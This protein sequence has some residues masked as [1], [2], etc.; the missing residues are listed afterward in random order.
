MRYSLAA[1]ALAGLSYAVPQAVKAPTTQP[2][3]SCQ[4]TVSG[5]FQIQVVNVT[6]KRDVL[7]E[8]QSGSLQITLNNGVL[9]D[10]SGRTGE[11]VA[12]HQFQFDQILQPN[13]IYTSGWAV[14]SNGSLV[15][16]NQAVFYQC[17]SGNFYN[18][19][20]QSQGGQCGPIYIQTIG[21]S[22][23]SGASQSGSASQAADGQVTQASPGASSRP[24]SQVTDGQPSTSASARPDG[25]LQATTS[26]AAMPVQQITDGQIQATTA[27]PSSSGRPVSQI[28]DGQIQA[29]TARPSSSSGRPVSAIS[30]GQLQASTGPANATSAATA[31]ATYTGAAA[32]PTLGSG[33]LGI[34]AIA[35]AML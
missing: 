24:V 5:S 25:Q 1:L 3:S 17:L 20:D 26:A 9:K 6:K 13:A 28:G 14:C 29:T 21:T 4:K 35:V 7:E 2:A 31:V 8:R 11:V 18:L 30:D 19:Y 33:L 15:L 22:G 23:S 10:Q 27:R 34:A 16:G 12:N 32:L